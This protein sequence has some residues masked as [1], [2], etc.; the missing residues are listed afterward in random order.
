MELLYRQQGVDEF[1][2]AGAITSWIDVN[3]IMIALTVQSADQRVT[4]DTTV[5]SGR[6]ERRFTNIV[7][8]RNRVP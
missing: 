3:A 6:V 7:T 2:E 5:N 8:L 4:T 1:R